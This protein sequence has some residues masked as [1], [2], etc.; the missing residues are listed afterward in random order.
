[1]GLVIEGTK[2]VP[3]TRNPSIA[4]RDVLKNFGTNTFQKS[5]QV[6][7]KFFKKNGSWYVRDLKSPNKLYVNLEE[8]HSEWGPLKIGDII[9]LGTQYLSEDG[10]FVCEFLCKTR[11]KS[12]ITFVNESVIPASSTI[13]QDHLQDGES[14][15]E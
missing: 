1:M 5:F 4:N 8:V 9:G 13:Q 15:S 6:P 14:S 12:K 2:S 7:C 3:G 11:L 10:G